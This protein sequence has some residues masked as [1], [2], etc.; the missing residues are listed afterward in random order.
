MMC[1]LLHLTRSEA[2]EGLSAM[3]VFLSSRQTPKVSFV[4]DDKP[5]LDVG[6]FLAA[7]SAVESP[8]SDSD[9]EWHASLKPLDENKFYRFGLSNNFDALKTS[10]TCC[11]FGRFF[12]LSLKSFWIFICRR[13]IIYYRKFS[14]IDTP[15]HARVYLQILARSN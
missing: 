1:N 2:E 5:C 4:D 7:F 14:R 8:E 11:L 3:S 9:K 13:H 10:F 15:C 6:E 12:F